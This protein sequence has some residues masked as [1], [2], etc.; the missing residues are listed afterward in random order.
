M[1]EPPDFSRHQQEERTTKTFGPCPGPRIGGFQGP[2]HMCLALGSGQE[3]EGAGPTY[4]GS[5]AVIHDLQE[6]PGYSTGL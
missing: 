5:E 4:Y 1:S 3:E 2:K 6:A